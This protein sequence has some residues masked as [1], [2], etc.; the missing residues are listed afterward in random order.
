MKQ[1]NLAVIILNYNDSDSAIKYVNKIKKY[2][3]ID[4]ILLVDN[5]SPDNSY[6]KMLHLKSDKID[7][8]LTDGNY[9][10]A[11]GNNFGVRYLNEQYGEFKYIAISNPDVEVPQDSYVQCLEFL[12][13]HKNVAICAPR[14]LDINGNKHQLSGWKVRS[15]RG[16]VHDSS[17]FI[18]RKINKPH[19]ERYPENYLNKKV[20]Y[21]DCVAG[22][23]FIIKHDI[24]KKMGYFDENT[25]LYYEEDILGTKLVHNGYK[26]VV[27]NTC[28]FKHYESV[29][30][31]KNMSY[32]NKYKNLQKSKRYYH[33]HYD[34]QVNKWYNKWKIIVLDL[35]TLQEILS[36]KLNNLKYSNKILT[37]IRNEGKRIII[38]KT[39]FLILTYLLWPIF[40]FMRL[41]R[42]KK[43]VLYFSLVT[44]KWIKQRPHFVALGLTEKF[45]VD[46]TYQSLVK[47][48]Q[49]KENAK[50][51]VNNKVQYD[52]FKVKPFKIYPI[53]PKF[54]RINTYRNFIRTS[55]YNYDN[56]IFTQPHQIDFFFLKLLKIK[57]TNIYY[58]CMDNYIGW[59]QDRNEYEKKERILINYAKHVFVSSDKLMKML[60]KKY[61]VDESKFTVIRN[62]YD[63]N[64]FANTKSVEVPLKKP[65]ITYIGTIDEWFDFKSVTTFAK[66]H[67]DINLYIIGPCGATIKTN[68]SKI[69]LK[70]VYFPGPIEHD[71]VPSYIMQSDAM[72]MPFKLNEIIEYVD[73]VKM[74]EYLYYKKPVI[75]SYWDE[76]KQFDGMVS[77]YSKTEEFETAVLNALN[78]PFVETKAYKKIIKESTWENRIKDYLKVIK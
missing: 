61:G 37:K 28:N 20:A 16:D 75:S 3:C 34:K 9:G 7:V 17:T 35:V 10:Y 60:S 33:L 41:F 44:W 38:L 22:S 69:K 72:F 48:Y 23:F 66:K 47:K 68:I 27:L 30:V 39:F 13:K 58:E 29:T 40:Q 49:P 63:G 77:F 12:D 14:M 6:E 74:Y 25:F 8:I 54:N 31:D 2:K 45:K 59:E 50:S 21:V 15:F 56:I 67:P 76:L 1:N 46:Y 52:N 65:C 24:F 62:G 32:L 57:K 55:L 19:I 43:R 18:T 73:P 53:V 26:N 64:L 4:K 70:N 71:L 78:N 36:I 51:Y 11:Y 42:S 5:Q